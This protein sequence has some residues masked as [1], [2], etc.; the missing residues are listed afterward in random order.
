MEF[1]HA[2]EPGAP[3]EESALRIELKNGSRII[4]LPG[5]SDAN[6]RGYSGVN[7]LIVDEAARVPDDL[8]FAIRPMLAVSGGRM[9][10]LSTPYGKRGVFH[11]EYE[12]GGNSWQR[13]KVTAYDCPRISPA[14]L[15]EEK[16]ALGDYYFSQ[17][18]LCEF[19]ETTDQVFSYDLVMAA[20]SGDVK[21]LFGPAIGAATT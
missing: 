2:V 21:P 20:M 14:F 18:Y 5:K 19:R 9:V 10:M 7:L 3:A 16:A 12:T 8:Y 6:I 15:A 13:V 1:Y 4:A 11:T 17:E